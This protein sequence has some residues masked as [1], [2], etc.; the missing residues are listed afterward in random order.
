[1]IIES[2]NHLIPKSHNHRMPF[3]GDMTPHHRGFNSEQLNYSAFD[4]RFNRWG[5]KVTRALYQQCAYAFFSAGYRGY[6]VCSGSSGYGNPQRVKGSYDPTG[7][8][9]DP[10]HK[11]RGAQV[12]RYH[13]ISISVLMGLII[14]LSVAPAK[15]NPLSFQ[16]KTIAPYAGNVINVSTG[17][18]GG[19]L[20][21]GGASFEIDPVGDDATFNASNPASTV[22]LSRGSGQG[23]DLVVKSRVS[24]RIISAHCFLVE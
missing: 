16:C 24:E 4:N 10:A 8:T 21:V 3:I 17:E 20:L 7:I 23:W 19:D 15:A 5:V 6:S 12:K 9:Y 1:M 22:I 11:Q 2:Q 18:P 14:G 13:V